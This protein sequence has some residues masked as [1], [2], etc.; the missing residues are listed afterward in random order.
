MKQL[1]IVSQNFTVIALIT[2]HHLGLIIYIIS[3]IDHIRTE[4]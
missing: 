1:K 2:F 4:V 3:N